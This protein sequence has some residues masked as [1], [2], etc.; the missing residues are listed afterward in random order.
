VFSWCLDV[1]VFGC[2]GVLVCSTL[3]EVLL[4]RLGVYVFGYVGV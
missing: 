4:R 3:A 2:L 1:Y